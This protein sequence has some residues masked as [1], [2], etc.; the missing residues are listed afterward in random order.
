MFNKN[1]EGIL[2]YQADY[3]NGCYT[4]SNIHHFVKSISN[5]KSY[6]FKTFKNLMVLKA[7]KINCF[8]VFDIWEHEKNTEFDNN[9]YNNKHI[10]WY[11]KYKKVIT[12]NTAVKTGA[13]GSNSAKTK[14]WPYNSNKN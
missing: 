10:Q 11:F 8:K 1:L 2:S 7:G 14:N 4:E 6:S 13:I 9:V 5:R 3:Y 12:H